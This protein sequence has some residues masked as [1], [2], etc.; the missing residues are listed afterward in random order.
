MPD[1]FRKVKTIEN[2][3]CI[4]AHA[5]VLASMLTLLL[6]TI[7]GAAVWARPD[8]PGKPRPEPERFD[9]RVWIGNG[10]LV[11][12]EDVVLQSYGVPPRDYLLVE[13]YDY[14]GRW[15]PPSTKG[16]KNIEGWSITLEKGEGDYCGTYDIN[17][18]DLIDALIA[19]N[20]YPINDKDVYCFFLQ[21]RLM[22]PST[23]RSIGE[24][25]DYWFI[26][27]NFE[28]GTYGPLPGSDPP[29]DVPHLLMLKGETDTGIE[30]EGE[31]DE[32]TDTWTVYFNEAWFRVTENTE[33]GAIEEIWTGKLSFT[34]KIKRT[35]VE[36]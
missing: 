27:I 24:K 33:S 26:R 13:D 11:S 34:I 25:A 14:S 8:R 35:L 2:R 9:Y 4:R 36:P 10:P 1:V 28:L 22:L 23:D 6:S 3:K 12:P 30:P 31:Y 32:T 29:I 15:L 16:K 19:N 20:V 5:F 21:H 7:I 18:Q 17:D